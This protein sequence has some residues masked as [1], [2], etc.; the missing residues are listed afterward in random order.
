MGGGALSLL[1]LKRTLTKLE[2]VIEYVE[3]PDDGP[4]DEDGLGLPVAA[5]IFAA[6]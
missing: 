4:L 2:G 6:V 1:E 3:G 5:A